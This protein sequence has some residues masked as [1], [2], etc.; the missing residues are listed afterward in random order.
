M[1]GFS[2]FGIENCR[3]SAVTH[4]GSSSCLLERM[5]RSLMHAD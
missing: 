1:E 2:E 5:I 4:L 3:Y